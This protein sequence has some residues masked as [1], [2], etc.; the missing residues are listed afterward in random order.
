MPRASEHAEKTTQYFHQ[1]VNHTRCCNR[2]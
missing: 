2:S 1:T